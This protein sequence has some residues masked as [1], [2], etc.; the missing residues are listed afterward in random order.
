MS[1]L[2]V[3]NTLGNE[4]KLVKSINELMSMD[5]VVEP[6]IPKARVR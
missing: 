4:F 2:K 3:A 5:I 6:E 1:K